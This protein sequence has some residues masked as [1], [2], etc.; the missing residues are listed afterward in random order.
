[1]ST[2]SD[3]EEESSEAFFFE[4]SSS[5]MEDQTPRTSSAVTRA[6]P[7]AA[8]IQK[9]LLLESALPFAP[10]PFVPFSGRTWITMGE[11]LVLPVR[12]DLVLPVREDLVFVREHL[13]PEGGM[14]VANAVVGT[15]VLI[16]LRVGV[17]DSLLVFLV[18]DCGGQDLKTSFLFRPR[19]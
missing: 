9:R 11:D 12:E 10:P 13:V 19:V 15:L 4:E 8:I 7:T 18:A 14:N 16:L 1:M 17:L 2:E 6:I 5:E 3:E